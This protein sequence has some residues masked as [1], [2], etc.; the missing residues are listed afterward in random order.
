M[1]PLR[2][3]AH[4]LKTGA[5]N[6]VYIRTRLCVS[7]ISIVSVSLLLLGYLTLDILFLRQNGPLVFPDLNHMCSMEASVPM[8][9]D[10]HLELFR[11]I[12][13]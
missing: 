4:G 13:Q 3:E 7:F 2:E 6:N 8:S 5:R 1:H 9:S 11:G 12:R 10:E